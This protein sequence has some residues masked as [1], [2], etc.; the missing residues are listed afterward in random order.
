MAKS[1]PIGVI[2]AVIALALV[3]AAFFGWR[4]LSGGPNGDITQE[5][6]K[7]YDEQQKKQQEHKFSSPQDAAKAGAPMGSGVP[8]APP[9]AAPPGPR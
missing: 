6:I 4:V 2:V 7:Y 9:A 3:I 8:V 5:K 1:L